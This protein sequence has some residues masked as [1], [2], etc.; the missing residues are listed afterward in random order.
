MNKYF[1]YVLLITILFGCEKEVDTCSNSKKI[2]EINFTCEKIKRRKSGSTYPNV[3][4]Y[5]PFQVSM[6]VQDP[7]GKV[8][9][10]SSRQIGH[11]KALFVIPDDMPPSSYEIKSFDV[12]SIDGLRVMFHKPD[13]EVLYFLLASDGSFKLDSTIPLSNVIRGKSFDWEKATYVNNDP[14]LPILPW[15]SGASTSVLRAVSLN[16]KKED[17]WVM[18]HNTFGLNRDLNKSL[19]KYFLLYNKYTGFLR[20]WY[21][22]EGSNSYSS[23]KYSIQLKTRSSALNFN[24]DFAKAMDCRFAHNFVESVSG[25]ANTVGSRGLSSDTWYLYEYELAFDEK[26]KTTSL[27]ESDFILSS[28]GIKISKLSLRGEQ[29][30]S[31]DGRVVFTAPG[32]NLFNFGN[33]EIQGAGIDK[34]HPQKHIEEKNT[35]KASVKTIDPKKWWNTLKSRLSDETINAIGSGAASLGTNIINLVTDPIGNCLNSLVHQSLSNEGSVNL[36]MSTKI[37][38]K[39]TIESSEPVFSINLRIPGIE[40]SSRLAYLYDKPLGVFNLSSTPV[41]NYETVYNYLSTRNKSVFQYYKIDRSSFDF[42]L[43]PAIKDEIEVLTKKT[44]LF[45]YRR[46]NGPTKLAGHASVIG[47]PKI[48]CSNRLVFSTIPKIKF[49]KIDSDGYEYY[50]FNESY[51]IPPIASKSYGLIY[52]DPSIP[53]DFFEYY[54]KISPLQRFVVK[55]TLQFKVKSTGRNITII[56]SYL[57]KYVYEQKLR[58]YY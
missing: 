26:L 4:K 1:I 21:W 19:K 34:D 33:L 35:D 30:G 13:S 22:H 5:I 6:V 11:N 27:N 8:Y 39:G 50:K 12:Y 23:N 43:N 17:G 47:A 41:V 9:N 40:E 53:A 15:I 29:N 49:Q 52:D 51:N 37:D 20:M 24:S 14:R 42:V 55:A 38:F 32:S 31:I 7:N 36:T 10:L 48:G 44:E 3:S 58:I 56:K 25:D 16:H 28:T 45:Y 57:P 2:V 18:I 46:Y 54:P